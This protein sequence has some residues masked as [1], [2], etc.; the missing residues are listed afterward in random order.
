MHAQPTIGTP[1]PPCP[2]TRTTTTRGDTPHSNETAYTD[3]ARAIAVLPPPADSAPADSPP[4]RPH[5]A[6]YLHSVDLA[7]LLN[8]AL[9]RRE[10]LGE[11]IL[12]QGHRHPRGADAGRGNEPRAREGRHAR[13]RRRPHGRQRGGRSTHKCVHGW[14]GGGW[15]GGLRV[16]GGDEER[17]GA[18]RGRGGGR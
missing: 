2:H 12:T 8:A 11:A 3:A 9:G 15:S 18:R 1:A 5:A 7:T 17:P 14:G 10:V 4:P 16:S 6:S 13:G